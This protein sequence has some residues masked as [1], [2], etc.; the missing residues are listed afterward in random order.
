M[1]SR[2][3]IAMG[4]YNGARFIREQL[5]SLNNQS[6]LPLELVVCDDH[7]TDD[8]AEIVRDFAET[9]AFPVRFQVNETRLGFADNFL[10]ASLLCSGELIAFCDQD[11]VW[12]PDK[13]QTCVDVFSSPD[14]LLCSHDADLCDVD[15]KVTGGHVSGVTTGRYGA[16]AL[17]PWDIYFGFTCVFR[18]E[19]LQIIDPSL[20]PN[21]DRGAA[22][23]MSHDSW[24]Y[25]V[26]NS[27]GDTAF[28]AKRLAKYRQH[29]SNLYGSNDLS[30]L[31][32]VKK[33]VREYEPYLRKYRGLAHGR[34]KA[35]SLATPPPE[36][37]ARVDKAHLFWRN[38][39]DQYDRRLR[40]ATGSWIG[41]RSLTVFELWKRGV[42]DPVS[43]G[44]AGRRALAEDLVAALTQSLPLRATRAGQT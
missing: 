25:F 34:A 39:E 15:G 24:V 19:L 5:D 21:D 28:V 4:T 27:V 1:T 38:L 44:G 18:R 40:V 3:S 17:K 42:Y 41:N 11:D 7:S 26:G 37:A 20:R 43:K 33:L 8:T 29:G 36:L 10:K 22:S 2:V 13:L 9:A 32:K 35:L 6:Y 30:T 23:K 14:I 31:Q 12:Y 16:L